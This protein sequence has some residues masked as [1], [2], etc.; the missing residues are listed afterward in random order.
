[1]IVENL[2]TPIYTNDDSHYYPKQAIVHNIVEEDQKGGNQDE[3][4]T[5]TEAA[6][7][8]IKQLHLPNE[9]ELIAQLLAGKKSKATEIKDK[10]YHYLPYMFDSGFEIRYFAERLLTAVAD[11]PLEIYFNGDDTLTEFKINC[12][13][14][15]GERWNYIGRY[16]PDFLMLQRDDKG[17]IH[18]VLIIETKGEG[19]AAKFVPRREFMEQEFL[20]LNNEKFG[21]QRFDFLYIEDTMTPDEQTIKTINRIKQFFN[22]D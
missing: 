2:N 12:Y 18:K 10:T 8:Q 7:N 13:H 15:V 11:R 16:V 17:K 6:I 3:N 1:L 19:Y 14:R 20:R 4:D 22:I 5:Q 21:Y 9:E